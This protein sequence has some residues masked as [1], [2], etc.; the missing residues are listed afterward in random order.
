MLCDFE[1]SS[2]IHHNGLRAV[3]KCVTALFS[4]PAET[5]RMLNVSLLIK[6][7]PDVV[8]LGLGSSDW[9]LVWQKTPG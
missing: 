2:G 7:H 9:N 1:T 4:D 5:C 8:F 6:R 3:L